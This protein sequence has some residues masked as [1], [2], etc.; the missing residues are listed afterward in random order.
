MYYVGHD[1]YVAISGGDLLKYKEEVKLIFYILNPFWNLV[2]EI[3]NPKWHVHLKKRKI[4]KQ[5]N[6]RK[7]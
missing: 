2:L 7:Q 5:V 1:I 3:F 6:E 4:N